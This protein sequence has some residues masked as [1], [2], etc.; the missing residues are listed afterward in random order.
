MLVQLLLSLNWQS[1]FVLHTRELDR[2]FLFSLEA[3]GISYVDYEI[4]SST[5]EHVSTIVRD[6][7][8]VLKP[9]LHLLL[10]CDATTTASVLR[11]LSGLCRTGSNSSVDWCHISRVLVVGTADD[12]PVFLDVD[13]QVENVALLELPEKQVD[14]NTKPRMWTLMFRPTG[15]AFTDVTLSDKTTTNLTEVFPN[16]KYGYNGRRFTLVMKHNSY[17]FGFETVNGRRVFSYPFRIM[18]ILAHYM[19]FSYTVIPPRED[20]WGKDVNG[21][22][23][24][25]LGT[26]QRREADFASDMLTIHYDRAVAFDYI[27]LPIAESKRFI[28]YKKEEDADGD[29][30]LL[31]LRAFQPTVL[32]MFGLSLLLEFVLLS[33]VRLI[34][35]KI[36]LQTNSENNKLE[37]NV[38]L[39]NTSAQ[40]V[41]QTGFEVYGATIKQGSTR[42]SSTDSERILTAGWWMFTIVFSAVYCGTIMATLAVKVETPPFSNMAELVSRTDYKIGYDSSS[43]TES[44]I[45]NSNLSYMVAFNKRIKDQ[46]IKDTGLLSNNITTHLQRV[47][48]GKYAFITSLVILPLARAKCQLEAIDSR[49]SSTYTAF[50]LPKSSPL[51]P[52]L[53]KAMYRLNDNGILQRTF[54]EWLESVPKET[55]HVEDFPKVVS[56]IKTQSIFFAVGIGVGSSSL[57]LIAETV[58]YRTKHQICH[59]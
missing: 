39:K 7:E 9:H 5:G 6:V 15:R 54:Q 19:N 47:H 31:F 33:S 42:T 13:I 21:S 3:S 43:I 59:R 30:L 37:G 26:L 49:L 25:V 32:L 8:K 36:G 11:H 58:W 23:T 27:L 2:P 48:E 38:R 45:Q 18:K 55:C 12:L 41:L 1:V 57:I 46:S 4:S 28:L 35:K 40:N 53:Q 14:S 51:K 50:Y 17:G 24:G 16:V 34:G 52:E 44:I 20:A 56:L 10:I 22:W 29:H